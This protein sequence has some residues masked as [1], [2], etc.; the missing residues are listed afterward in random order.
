M[1][2]GEKILKEF[3]DEIDHYTKEDYTKLYNKAMQREP[4]VYVYKCELCGK[5]VKDY[6]P[7]YCCN[8]NE[9]GC[10]GLPLEP[11]YCSQECLDAIMNG[12]GK[13]MEQRR[14]DAGIE[15]WEK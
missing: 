5:P 3:I 14:I 2:Q 10:M 12:I 6:E 7:E 15:K 8:G 11:C 13:D 4:I 9:C 1:N